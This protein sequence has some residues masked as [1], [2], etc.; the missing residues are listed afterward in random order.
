MPAPLRCPQCNKRLRKSD[1]PGV[2]TYCASCGWAQREEAASDHDPTLEPSAGLFV[3]LLIGWLFSLALVLGPY[4]A[5]LVYV[6]TVEFWM[7][8]TYWLVMFIYLAAAATTTPSYDRSNMGIAGGLIDN[9]LTYED[10]MN[11]MGLF[12]ALVLIPG[13]VFSWTIVAT[14]KLAFG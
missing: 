4:V 14:W 11:R 1:D 5:L 6:P 10:D 12:F 3:K 7:H 9:P 2:K 13:K 8:L